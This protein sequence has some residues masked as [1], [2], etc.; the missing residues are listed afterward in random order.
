M[1]LESLSGDGR[2][3]VVADASGRVLAA[4]ALACARLGIGVGEDLWGAL[5]LAADALPAGSSGHGVLVGADG[6]R[7]PAVLSASRVSLEGRECIAVCIEFGQT[8]GVPVAEPGSEA[9]LSG[10][11]FGHAP[12]GAAVLEEIFENSQV[13]MAVCNRDGRYIRV[14]R[15]F[16]E[17]LRYRPGELLAMRFH[18]VTHPDDLA[19][20]VTAHRAL[21]HGERPRFQMEKRYLR[22]DGR[23]VWAL[24]V[25]SEIRDCAG[26]VVMSIG[27]MLDIDNLK[28][29]EAQLQHSR[30]ALRA[31]SSHLDA[32][33]ELERK[34]IAQEIH[35]EMGQLL[36]AIKMDISLLRAHGASA[37][38]PGPVLE[39]MQRLADEG[40][41]AV[42]QIASRL[43]PGALDLGMVPAL[44]WLVSDFRQRFGLACRL[45]CEHEEIVVDDARR[46]AVFRIVQESLTNVV[47]H[48]EA[49]S[50][51]VRVSRPAA[52]LA[53][54]IEDDGRGFRVD[55][56]APSGL[57]VLGMRERAL[58]LGGRFE[59]E[60]APGAGTCVS[61]RLPAGPGVSGP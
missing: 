17:F 45:E 52:A 47:R 9:G 23:A 29:T 33:V 14:N 37:P 32:R 18:D 8:E 42:R 20:N 36:T 48:A 38:A 27:Q 31:L 28:R 35:D 46:T 13:G 55:P 16:C 25:V 12:V 49:S 51:V 53:I 59:I 22:K 61:I 1:V 5:G 50:V 41:R 58:A 3:V 60:S 15:A 6:V 54:R 2:G 57:G 21:L 56:E 24:M 44:D 40:I 4:D 11:V 34:H 26:Q 10:G 43:R 19:S 7:M 30:S 39:S